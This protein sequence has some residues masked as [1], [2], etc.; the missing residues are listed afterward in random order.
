MSRSFPSTAPRTPRK[1]RYPLSVHLRSMRCH[2]RF[3]KSKLKQ[4]VLLNVARQMWDNE[5]D[6]EAK[7][8]FN[9]E[10]VKMCT[11][12]EKEIVWE[13]STTSQNS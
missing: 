13:V 6:A 2:R 1:T 7:V 9:S 10:F 8:E 3:E 5:M 4:N 12:Q 11:E